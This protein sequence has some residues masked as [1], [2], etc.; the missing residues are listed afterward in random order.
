VPD[1]ELLLRPAHELAGLVR[2][3]EVT[4]RELVTASLERIEALDEQVGAFVDV[5]GA[6][7][8]A[9]AEAVGPGDPRPFAGVPIAVKNNRPVEGLRLTFCA[10]LLGDHVAGHDAYVVARLRAAGFIIVGTT[11]LPEFGILPVSEPSRFGPVRNP[12][13]LERTPG[14]S[15]GGSAAAVAA[16][17]V[18]IAHGNDGGG[19]TRIPAACC[20]L[21]GL[22]PARGRISHGPDLGDSL[23]SIDGVLTRTVTETAALLDLLSGYEIGDATWAPPPDRPFADAAAGDP[24]R[25][26]VALTLAP[27]LIDTPV[28]PVCEAAAR[29]AASLLEELGH[30]V[31][32]ATPPWTVP[33]MLETFSAVFGPLVSLAVGFGALLAGRE[34]TFEDMEPLSWYLWRRAREASALDYAAAVIALQGL[35]RAVVGFFDDVDVVLTPSLAQRPVAIGE[36]DASAPD[37]AATFRRSGEF[38]PFTAIANVTGQ[39][40][41]SLPLSHGV[42]GLPSGIQLIGRP[43]DEATLLALAAQLEA[44]SPWAGRRPPIAARSP[45]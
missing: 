24:G 25:L 6:R 36:I 7:A 40:A 13:D 30:E 8:L 22:K 12:W 2:G 11:K 41:V 16:G 10:D 35:A 21:V 3:G 33:G 17:M 18:P 42:D 45:G 31:R 34:P 26:R 39:P 27:P 9:A 20:G 44:A 28:D 19:S 32:E 37:P 23:L 15:S 5:D 43:A 4:A 1:A 14:G 38:T 29:D